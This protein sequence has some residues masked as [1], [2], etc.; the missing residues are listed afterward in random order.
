MYSN[1]LLSLYLRLQITSTILDVMQHKSTNIYN[2]L[3]PMQHKYMIN[4]KND[5][6]TD[7]SSSSS[8]VLTQVRRTLLHLLAPDAWILS[9][10][11]TP[12][13]AF[14]MSYVVKPIATEGTT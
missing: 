10:G 7:S 6:A 2:D 4:N 1:I 5:K 12:S 8:L 11:G 3:H 13:N 14:I 9:R